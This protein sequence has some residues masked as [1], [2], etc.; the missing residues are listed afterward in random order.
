MRIS[1]KDAGTSARILPSFDPMAAFKRFGSQDGHPAAEGEMDLL[2]VSSR[3]GTL[4]F[5][6]KEALAL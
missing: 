1:N 2:S 3:M 6:S 4:R 5:V